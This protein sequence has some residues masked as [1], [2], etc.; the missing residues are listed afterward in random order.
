MVSCLANSCVAPACL[1]VSC[2]LMSDTIAALCQWDSVWWITGH[3]LCCLNCIKAAQTNF[4]SVCYYLSGPRKHSFSGISSDVSIIFSWLTT[5]KRS[6]CHTG[7]TVCYK[8]VLF[9]EVYQRRDFYNGQHSLVYKSSLKK[10]F[11]VLV[12]SFMSRSYNYG[13]SLHFFQTWASRVLII[14]IDPYCT[15]LVECVHTEQSVFLSCFTLQAQPVWKP[16][17][18]VGCRS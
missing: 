13:G 17:K 9:S 1:S 11:S 15:A 18:N 3:S 6:S 2:M 5:W 8:N 7:I 10:E 12:D 14:S 4:L 16:S